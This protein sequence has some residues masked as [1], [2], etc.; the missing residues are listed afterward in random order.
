MCRTGGQDEVGGSEKYRMGSQQE[1]R[2]WKVGF[3]RREEAN[4]VLGL[5]HFQSGGQAKE[6]LVRAFKILQESCSILSCDT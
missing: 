4:L 2:E 1:K 3:P 5:L 6:P